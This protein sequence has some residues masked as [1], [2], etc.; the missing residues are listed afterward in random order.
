MNK[1]FLLIFYAIFFINSCSVHKNI[2]NNFIKKKEDL[3]VLDFNTAI[4][5]IIINIIKLNNIFH[6]KNTLFF[7]DFPENHTNIN[8]D[9]IKL[10][11]LIK[12]KFKQINQNIHFLKQETIEN[13]K[14]KL[15]I[16]NIKK[17]L[18][19]SVAMLLSR[20]NHVT[21][22][23]HSYIFRENN[24]YSLKIELILVKTGEIVFTQIEKFY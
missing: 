1:Y 16:S 3:I 6:Y 24:I 11:N 21:Y 14:K 8:L 13:D 12:T 17:N 4:E 20:N 23:L 2:N 19:T 9:N 22:Y 10:T 7:I 15:G 18:E 5:K